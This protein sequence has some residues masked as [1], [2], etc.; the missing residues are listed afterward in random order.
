[1]NDFEEI[2]NELNNDSNHIGKIIFAIIFIIVVI[3]A[4]YFGFDMIQNKNKKIEEKD[5]ETTIQSTDFNCS[6]KCEYTFHVKNQDIKVQYEVDLSTEDKHKIVINGNTIL[7]QAFNC[8]GP[9]K[10]VVLE[11]TFILQYR[12]QCEDSTDTLVSYDVNGNELFRYE[13]IDEEYPNLKLRNAIVTVK[14]NT[15]SFRATSINHKMLMLPGKQIDI[16]NS[17]LLEANQIMENTVVEASYEIRY[18]GDL[19]YQK[20]K[21]KGIVTLEK[22]RR[23]HDLNQS[24]GNN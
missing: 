7:D 13:F 17:D 11:D 9:I 12:N 8:G 14:N 5:K 21:R 20:P 1:M 24:C 6:D 22:Y 10:M 3:S 23:M 16:C 18:L 4:V 15:I 2:A 19:T